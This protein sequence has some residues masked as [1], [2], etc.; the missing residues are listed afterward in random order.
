[1]AGAQ[2]RDALLHLVINSIIR[3]ALQKPNAPSPLAA[4]A[5]PP[6]PQPQAPAQRKW[7]D[8][9]ADVLVGAEDSGPASQKYALICEKCFT[10]NGLV[11]EIAYPDARVSPFSLCLYRAHCGFYM[12]NTNARNAGIL[13]HRRGARRGGGRSYRPRRPRRRCLCRSVPRRPPRVLILVLTCD[14]ALF[15]RC[16]VVVRVRRG[17]RWIRSRAGSARTAR[18]DSSLALAISYGSN[19]Q[20]LEDR[21]RVTFT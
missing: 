12:Q 19:C 9:L 16:L 8:A 4:P 7:Y 1:M 5:P 17:W 11:P 6:P 10:H 13:T 21:R 20:I 3:A 15:G 2:G 14:G 18:T